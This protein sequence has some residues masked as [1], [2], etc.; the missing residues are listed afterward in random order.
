M[1]LPEPLEE[2][3]KIY[4]VAATFSL[5]QHI[6]EEIKKLRGEE[7]AKHVRPYGVDMLCNLRGVDPLSIFFEHTAYEQA[8]VKQYREIC[9]IESLQQDI[10]S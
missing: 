6:K 10:W 1:T 2:D 9:M 4:V 7:F 5:A 8:T 3:D